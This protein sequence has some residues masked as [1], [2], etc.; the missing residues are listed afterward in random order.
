MT[1]KKIY[2]ALDVISRNLSRDRIPFALI[3]ALALGAYGFPRY[4]ADIDLLTHG[5]DWPMIANLMG[6]LGYD[7]F[8]KTD[9]FARFKSE[10][11]VLGKI[12]YMFVVTPEGKKILEGRVFVEDELLGTTPVVQ[13]TD[14]IILK[15]MAIANNP[16]RRAKDEADIATFFKLHEQNLIPTCFDPLDLNKILI[17]AERFRQGD[18]IKKYV[19]GRLGSTGSPGGFGL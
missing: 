15:L 16:G 4:T 1:T 13:P 18:L 11:G 6:K 9:S 14:Y 5:R 17:F 7:C 19:Y 2:T 8:Q 3:G 10:F 12:D